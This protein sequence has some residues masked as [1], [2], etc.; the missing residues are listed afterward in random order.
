MMI[1]GYLLSE[2]LK[3][4]NSD[5]KPIEYQNAIKLVK[6]TN[7]SLDFTEKDYDTEREDHKKG[8][9]QVDNFKIGYINSNNRFNLLEEDK[10]I[11]EK[12]IND[13]SGVTKRYSKN[14]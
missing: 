7:F 11:I 1:N 5:E 10:N 4:D 12:A 13:D 14:L 2:L 9:I 6:N 8:E 3:E